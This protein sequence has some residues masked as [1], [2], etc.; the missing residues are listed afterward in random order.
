VVHGGYPKVMNIWG[1]GFFSSSAL[2]VECYVKEIFAMPPR[3][4]G[5]SGHGD[6]F[7]RSPNAERFDEAREYTTVT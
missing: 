2:V 5:T 1:D 3:L 6:R 7:T 4:T